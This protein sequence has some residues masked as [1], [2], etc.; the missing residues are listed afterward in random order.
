MS[1]TDDR[2]HEGTG[3][4]GK[5]DGVDPETALRDDSGEYTEMQDSG[6]AVH[7]TDDVPRDEDDDDDYTRSQ[8]DV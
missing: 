6:G 7:G 2:E 4:T 5:G 8:V 1:V 3:G